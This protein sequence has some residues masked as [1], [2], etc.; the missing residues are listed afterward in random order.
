MQPKA[1]LLRMHPKALMSTWKGIAPQ[2]PHLPDPWIPSTIDNV[3]K[4]RARHHPETGVV[5]RIRDC[6]AALQNMMAGVAPDFPRGSGEAQQPDLLTFYDLNGELPMFSDLTPLSAQLLNPA[7]AKALAIPLEGGGGSAASPTAQQAHS[8]QPAQ[9]QHSAQAQQHSAAAQQA[10]AQL[11]GFPY[12]TDYAQMAQFGHPGVQ[13]QQAQQYAQ[14]SQ[15]QGGYGQGMGPLGPGGQGMGQQRP[16]AFQQ[17]QQMGVTPQGQPLYGWANP[18]DSGGGM[19]MPPMQSTFPGKSDDSI[20]SGLPATPPNSPLCVL[21]CRWLWSAAL[22]RLAGPGRAEVQSAGAAA[23]AAF[24]HASSCVRSES[25][26]L[27][28]L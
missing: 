17:M 9:Q 25:L 24:A 19:A 26:T 18:H 5:N 10:A 14:L 11:Q 3:F 6:V 27:R 20:C 12:Q 1:R 4:A 22:S 7:I 8:A 23:A 13:Q 16:A 2:G 28:L 21:T 15:M